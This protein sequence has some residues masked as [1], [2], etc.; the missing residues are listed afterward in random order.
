MKTKR[1]PLLAEL[2]IEERNVLLPTL[3]K[4]LK[5]KSN[6]LKHIKGRELVDWFRANK[7]KIGYKRAFNNQRL[8]KLTNYIRVYGLAALCASNDGYWITRDKKEITD[9]VESF[10]G[11]VAS[12]Q[13]AIRGLEGI[14]AEIE[15][16]NSLLGEPGLFEML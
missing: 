14:L 4:A 13:A 16:E 11:R 3:I 5:L 12:Q 7:D 1:K 6:D 8:M 9:M 2:T 15:L 10:K